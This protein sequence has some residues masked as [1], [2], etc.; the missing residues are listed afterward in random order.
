M[1][2]RLGL[3]HRELFYLENDVE[4]PLPR[5]VDGKAPDGFV[6][7][8]KHLVAAEVAREN[9]SRFKRALTDLAWSE[10]YDCRSKDEDSLFVAIREGC[11]P[12]GINHFKGLKVVRGML[13]LTRKAL[14]QWVYIRKNASVFGRVRPEKKER[15]WLHEDSVDLVSRRVVFCKAI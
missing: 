13:R 6:K 8:S 7:V 12:Y 11:S 2:H 1:L 15:V 4:S 10:P 5:L 3:W 14:W 9:S